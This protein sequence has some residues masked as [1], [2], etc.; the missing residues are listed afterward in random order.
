M[1]ATRARWLIPTG[2]NVILDKKLAFLMPN[3]PLTTLEDA[4]IRFLGCSNCP[5]HCTLTQHRSARW[6]ARVKISPGLGSFLEAV[7]KMPFPCLFPFSRGHCSPGSWHLS[8]SS[9]LSCQD[10]GQ[11]FTWHHLI[12]LSVV[13]PLC[14]SFCLPFLLLRTLMITVSRITSL[15]QGQLIGNLK[16]CLLAWLSLAM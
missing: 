2:D 12:S 6:K 10:S 5:Q 3:I 15:T 7:G 9:P 8:P 13:S 11:V 14:L 4:C 16:M 1:A